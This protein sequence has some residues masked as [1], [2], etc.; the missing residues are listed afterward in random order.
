MGTLLGEH[1]HQLFERSQWLA[2]YEVNLDFIALDQVC[3]EWR[4][5][6]RIVPIPALTPVIVIGE[7]PLQALDVRLSDPVLKSLLVF[8]R[9]H[10]ELVTVVSLLVAIFTQL[11]AI[12]VPC[13][14]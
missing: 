11:D 14:Q 8:R 12:D 10:V 1:R 13:H 9:V 4:V 7:D 5:V 6:E 3:S 2:H